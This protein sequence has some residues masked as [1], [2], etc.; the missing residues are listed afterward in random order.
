MLEVDIDE[1][2]NKLYDLD[3]ESKTIQKAIPRG[4]QK[5]RKYREFSSRLSEVKNLK[6]DI[7]NTIDALKQIISL[8][9][10]IKDEVNLRI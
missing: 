10:E 7:R 3:K 1:N 4:R 2:T 5:N 8:I 9:E 6:T